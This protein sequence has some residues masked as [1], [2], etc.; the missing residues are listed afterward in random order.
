[1]NY[2]IARLGGWYRIN[3]S[4]ILLTEF[5]TALFKVAFS[6][7]WNTSSLRYNDRG[8]GTYEVNLAYRFTSHAPAK[9]RY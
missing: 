6:Y 9:S 8:I 5:E 4:F 7:D 1:M 3:D 2:G